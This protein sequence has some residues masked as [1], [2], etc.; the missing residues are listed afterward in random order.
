MLEH[1]S[2][3]EAQAEPPDDGLGRHESILKHYVTI[4][5]KLVITIGVRLAN[6]VAVDL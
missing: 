3:K 4:A 5:F 6:N 2:D 1:K